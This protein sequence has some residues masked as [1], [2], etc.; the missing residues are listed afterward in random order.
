MNK[1]SIDLSDH[2]LA[3][4]LDGK[5]D[6]SETELVLAYLNEDKENFEDFMNIRSAITAET[7]YP[8][9]IDIEERLN[10]VKQHI[11]S[12]NNRKKTFRKRLYIATSFAAAAMI[13]GI[14]FLLIFINPEKNNSIT[15]QEKNIENIINPDTVNEQVPVMHK[16]FE[17]DLAENELSEKNMQQNKNKSKKLIPDNDEEIIELPVQIQHQ[18]MAYKTEANLFEM[19]KPAKTPYI[20]L[21]KNLDKTFDFKWK[22]NAEKVEVALKDKS[23]K[24]LLEK[25]VSQTGLHIKYEDYYKYLEI[26]W[27]LK[28]IFQDG[29]TEKK[30]GILQLMTD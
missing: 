29:T 1:N 9:E 15:A 11:A 19:V 24:I 12:S 27:E 18:N 2:L 30:T 8:L 7:E 16:N 3:K 14:V 28:A 17:N 21:Y 20:V 6:A 4:F 13:S 5:T 22:T 26:H 10:V 23:G 25:D